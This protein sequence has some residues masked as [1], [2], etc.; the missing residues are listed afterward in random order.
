MAAQNEVELNQTV[1]GLTL[2]AQSALAQGTADAYETLEQQVNRFESALR[3]I[4]Q[5]RMA[6]QARE[7]IARL[8]SRDPLSPEDQ[9]AIR[10]LIVGDA[11]QYVK[12][13]NNLNDWL[14]EL[15]R[16]SQEMERLARSTEDASI[17]S[18]RGVVKDTVRL[19]PNIRS[20]ME[21][22]GRVD[23]FNAAFAS[24]DNDNRKLLIQL[25]EE[26]LSSPTR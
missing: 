7:V 2:L 8:K 4:Q 20:Y 14:G 12:Q 18:L 1:K 13:E 19:L 26:K 6:S 5:T 3:E 23:K 16:L 24:L 25:L 11:A 9:A 15:Q 17:G 22:K 21:E 10:D